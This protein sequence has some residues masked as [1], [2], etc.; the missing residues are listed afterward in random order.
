M[1]AWGDPGGLSPLSRRFSRERVS[2]LDAR[3]LVSPKPRP[4]RKRADHA[5][6]IDFCNRRE[7]R[8]HPGAARLPARLRNSRGRSA[9]E[10]RGRQ[11]P[12][13]RLGVELPHCRSLRPDQACPRRTRG[14]L[15]SK[16]GTRVGQWFGDNPGE[17]AAGPCPKARLRPAARTVRPSNEPGYLHAARNRGFRRGPS[18][19]PS[20]SNE[21][22]HFSRTRRHGPGRSQP[23][24][25]RQRNRFQWLSSATETICLRRL[26]DVLRNVSPASRCAAS[27]VFHSSDAIRHDQAKN[28]HETQFLCPQDVQMFFPWSLGQSSVDRWGPGPTVPQRLHM[29]CA[30]ASHVVCVRRVSHT[31][32]H[33]VHHTLIDADL[34]HTPPIAPSK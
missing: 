10:G 34:P 3:L 9:I 20:E 8:A 4:G 16:A 26:S 27:F 30:L 21:G 29:L 1:P 7:G 31:H 25:T 22:V 24:R 11:A 15:G 14:L 28:K 5:P 12:V 2:S 13:T 23:S 18:Q 17:G 33:Q 32:V 6:L 19:T